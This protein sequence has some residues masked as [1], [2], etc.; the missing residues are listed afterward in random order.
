MARKLTF[1]AATL[2]DI[3][4][5]AVMLANSLVT[6]YVYVYATTG[7][8]LYML[9]ICF[10]AM[11]VVAVLQS[12]FGRCPLTV[13][14]EWLHRMYDPCFDMKGGF[15]Q[16]YAKAILG[17]E[18]SPDQVNAVIIG[19]TAAPTVIFCIMYVTYVSTR[20]GM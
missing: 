10:A 13:L 18:L 17:L 3:I 20:V 14:S 8:G 1:I 9:Y 5:L 19:I 2:V 12:V 15:V 11:A 4:H 7:Q 16:H 6:Y